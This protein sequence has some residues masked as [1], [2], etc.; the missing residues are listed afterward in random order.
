MSD[1]AKL[2]PYD[3]VPTILVDGIHG[4]VFVGGN[5]KINFTCAVFNPEG[6]SPNMQPA[7]RL[8]MPLPV[9]EQVRDALAG[10]IEQLKSTTA[11]NPE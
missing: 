8:A 4:F 1:K 11:D 5:V 3:G 2:V 9:A 10:M 6:G 7:V